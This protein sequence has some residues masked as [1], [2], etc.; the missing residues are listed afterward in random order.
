MVK[1]SNSQNEHWANIR[2]LKNPLLRNRLCN[3]SDSSR[4][5]AQRHSL[6]GHR[7]SQG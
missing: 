6:F 3:R 2:H 1:I 5:F 4:S 7:Q